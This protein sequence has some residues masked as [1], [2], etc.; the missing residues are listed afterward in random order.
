MRPS[1]GEGGCA[2]PALLLSGPFSPDCSRLAWLHQAPLGSLQETLRSETNLNLWI[3]NSHLT[4][5]LKVIQARVD[6]RGPELRG[7]WGPSTSG[8]AP[9]PCRESGV[10]KDQRASGRGEAWPDRVL[11]PP[12]Q[13]KA[14]AGSAC[15]SQVPSGAQIIQSDCT[16][17]VTRSSHPSLLPACLQATEKPKRLLGSAGTRQNPRLGQG[18]RRRDKLRPLP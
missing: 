1:R 2:C 9:R 14:T 7:E 17:G 18:S 5:T 3:C 15:H 16:A 12:P 10:C 4:W 8:C 6:F 11:P 13:I